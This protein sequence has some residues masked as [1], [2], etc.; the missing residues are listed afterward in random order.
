[1]IRPGIG[2][3]VLTT[4]FEPESVIPIGSVGGGHDSNIMTPQVMSSIYEILC[5]GDFCLEDLSSTVD[6]AG[7]RTALE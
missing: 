2:R 1:M 7:W 5:V 6:H 3:S 4:E